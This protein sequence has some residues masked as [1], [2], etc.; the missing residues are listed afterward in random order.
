ME[1]A[2]RELWRRWAE[3]RQHGICAGCGR[4]TYV[5]RPDSR[6]RWLCLECWDAEQ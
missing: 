3:Y 2:V 6:Y 4:A 1:R 5:G